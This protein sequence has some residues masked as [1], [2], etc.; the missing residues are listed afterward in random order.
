MLRRIKET[1]F[2][3]GLVSTAYG[4]PNLMRSKHF[5]QKFLWI[6]FIISSSIASYFFV[7]EAVFDYLDFKV[8][9]NIQTI[10]K[11]PTEFPTVSMCG[12]KADHFTNKSLKNLIVECSFGY[13][14]NCKNDPDNYFEPFYSS[15]YGKCFRFNSGKNVT[16][17]SIPLLYSTIGGSDDSFDIKLN[18]S[19]DLAVWIHNKSSPIIIDD[20]NAHYSFRV[21]VSSNFFTEIIIEKIIE[22]KL[23]YPYNQCLEDVNTFKINKTIIDYIIDKLNQTYTQQKCLELCFDIDYI[24]TNPCNCTNVSIGEV[25]SKCWIKLE[26]KNMTTCTWMYK[27]NFY[28]KHVLDKCSL[29]CPLECDSIS[30]N[31]YSTSISNYNSTKVRIYYG[32]LKYTLLTQSPKMPIYSFVSNIGGILGLFLGFSVV[33][34]FEIIE[35]SF[36]ILIYTLSGLENK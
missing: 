2:E 33:N 30:Y 36:E 25:W 21:F 16:N 13:D 10:Y 15:Y 32:S 19:I 26:Y 31:I 11:Q 9:T 35:I 12:Y 18:S 27:K 20:K 4:I 3:F 5:H 7:N 28:S 22:D 17:N 6:L 23:P 8:V 1:I 14:N 24:K 29:Y 34:I